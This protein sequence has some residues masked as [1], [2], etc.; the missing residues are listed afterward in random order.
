MKQL[1]ALFKTE[2][3]ITGLIFRFTLGIVILPHGLQLLLGW[4]GGFGFT[5]SMNY[6][7]HAEGLPWVIGFL[8]IFLQ[9]AGALF[10]LIG[11]GGRLMALSMIGLFAGMI[12]TSHIQHGF[13]MNWLGDQ[14][15]E[16]FEF[17]LLVIGLAA[18]LLLNGSGKYSFDYWLTQKV[19]RKSLS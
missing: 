17:H 11:L 13:F 16:G 2:G 4:F 18:A 6:L 1:I 9:S 19:N 8:V 3:H 15:G 7:I 12:I 5:G 14:Q 10:I